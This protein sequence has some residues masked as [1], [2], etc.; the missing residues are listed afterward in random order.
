[1]ATKAQQRRNKGEGSI[2]ELSNGK[3]KVTITLG[4]GILLMFFFLPIVANI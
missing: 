3:Y 4:V 1:M 2:K